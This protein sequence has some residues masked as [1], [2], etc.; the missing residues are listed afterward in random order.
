MLK[1][2]PYLKTPARR[3]RGNMT[4]SEQLLWSRLRR[5]QILGVQFYRQSPIG[6]YIADF[7]APKARLVIEVDGSQHL[8]ADHAKKDEQRDRFMIN[9]GLKV[10]RFDNMQ[11]LQETGAVMEEIFRVVEARL[12]VGNPP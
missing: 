4:E 10:L 11:V 12:G 8:N 1:Y 6:N 5:K 3:L 2:H 7:Y 9:Q